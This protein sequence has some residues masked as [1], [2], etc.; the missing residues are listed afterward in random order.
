MSYS[1][2]ERRRLR[3]PE[4]DGPGQLVPAAGERATR[5]RSSRSSLLLLLVLVLLLALLVVGAFLLWRSL[6]ES[7]SG[8]ASARDSIDSGPEPDVRLV[9]G[10]GQV[11]V[12]GVEGL[13]SV[14]YEVAKYARGLD[15][16]AAEERASEVAIDISREEGSEILLETNGGRGTGADYVLRVPAGATVEV[17]SEAGDVEVGNLGGNV[18]VRAQAGDVA[19]QGTGGSVIIEAPRGDVSVSDVNTDTG[20]AELTVGSGDVTLEDLVV[21]TVEAAIE[22]GDVEISGRFSGG[23]RVFVETGDITARIP[24]E[25]ARE[26][27]LEASV[28]QV[29][30]EGG[31]TPEGETPKDEAP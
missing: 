1:G 28:G 26:L 15:P 4:R 19:V 17:E 20:Q 30:R 25:D 2:E 6:G 13:Q 18:T 31:E 10:P 14:E 11:R 12:E 3:Q 23:G 24:P 7:I 27:D 29:V 9:N 22:A 21:G 16:A 5:S 8:T